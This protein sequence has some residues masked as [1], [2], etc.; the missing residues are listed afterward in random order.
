[1]ADYKQEDYH[2][3]FAFVSRS[4]MLQPDKK[5]PAVISESA[6]GQSPFKSVFTERESFTA[7]RAPGE[8]E[9]DEPVFAAGEEYKVRPAKTVAGVPKFSLR[10]QLAEIMERGENVY[11]R[12]N[13]A[14]RLW[15]QVMG[16][17]LVHP[18]DMHHSSNPPSNPRLMNLLADEFAAMGFKVKPFLRELLLT[19]VYQ[20]SHRIEDSISV[21]EDSLAA[22]IDQLEQQ[23]AVSNEKSAA[24]DSEAQKALDQL[25]AA[26]TAAE[27]VRAAWAKARAAAAAAATKREPAAIVQQTKQTAFTSKQTLAANVTEAFKDAN[28]A[29]ALLADSKPLSGPL[30]TLKSRSEK[31]TAEAAKLQKELEAAA[32]ALAT[33]DTVLANANSAEQSEREKLNPLKDKMRQHRAILVKAWN[34]SEQAY[35][36]VIH[37]EKKSSFVE[38]LMAVKETAEV[39]PTTE[40]IARQTEQQKEAAAEKANTTEQEMAAVAKQ[41]SETQANVKAMQQEMAELSEQLTQRTQARQ[42]LSESLASLK[43]VASTLED[44]SLTTVAQTITASSTRAAS[45][46]GQ[47]EA[48]MDETSQRLQ[49]S[50]KQIQQ[51][52]ATASAMQQ[53]A[54]TAKQQAAAAST[55]LNELKQQLTTLKAAAAESQTVVTEQAT[56]QF[57]QAPV[58]SLSAEQLAWSILQVTGQIDIH[59][60][61]ELGKL[62]KSKPL[63]EDQAKDASVVAKRQAV[64]KA[65]AMKTLEKTVASFT[66]LF[67]AESGQ[68][69]DAFFATVDQALY[70][71]NGGP[72]QSWLRPSGNNLTGRLLK[73]E[74]PKKLAEELYL[75][76]LV[77]KPSP[78]EVKDVAEYLSSRGD[79]RKEAV[80]ELAWGLI[81]SAEFRFQY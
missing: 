9:I 13:I 77:R 16:R 55:R 28:E 23:R 46:M 25:D 56:N 32:K 62:N 1:M 60:A 29:A 7:A 48:E 20:R 4:S 21:R 81:T 8:A 65:A 72:I 47:T 54:E 66:S 40:A 39:L 11:F 30:A 15:A 2:G 27:P 79:S 75:S 68:P 33:A 35:E 57:Q 67:A 43:A 26:V 69:Q 63:T 5:K 70:F 44:E 18:V 53:Q 22:A 52:Q 12:R 78:D 71:A 45:A 37:A 36:R 80:Q 76:T 3:L 74:A 24:F 58:E 49:Q 61:V 38:E 42:A 34:Q 41:M 50:T 31:L 17:G 64:A 6:D 19:G 73:I 51:L 14:N 59:V 10:W